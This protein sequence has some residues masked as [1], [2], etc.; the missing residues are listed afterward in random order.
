[1]KASFA[2]LAGTMLLAVCPWAVAASS[3][4]LAVQGAITPSACTPSLS[5]G[6]VVDYGKIAARDLNY[7]GLTWLQKFNMNFA[8]NCDTPTLFAIQ[9]EDNRPQ[10]LSHGGFGFARASNDEPIGAFYLYISNYLADGVPVT[11][12]SSI[13][14][15]FWLPLVFFAFEP[16]VLTGFGHVNAGVA[17]PIPTKNLSVSLSIEGAIYQTKW[18][19]VH[20]EIPIDGSATLEV[21]YL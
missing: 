12:M 19:P 21:R 3:V 6:G 7:A 9:G 18:L 14:G 8:V 13:G 5:E 15:D 10:N 2:A 17:A 16:N 11:A 20:E 1:M 4:D